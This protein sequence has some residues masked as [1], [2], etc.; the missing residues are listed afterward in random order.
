[1]EIAA[2]AG[3]LAVGYAL[4][5]GGPAS[6]TAPVENEEEGFAGSV[7]YGPDGLPT[8]PYG[9]MPPPL[10]AEDRTAPGA[11]T[12][13]GKPRQPNRLADGE[14]DLYYKLPSGGE[15][16]SNP[17]TQPDLYARDLVFSA[18]APTL[19]PQAPP[20]AVTAQV[21]MNNDSLEAPPVY[22]SG[23]TVISSLTGLPITSEEFSHNNMTPF[24][25]GAPKQNMSDEANR[26]VLDNKVGTGYDQVGKREQAPLFDPHR[27]P[28]GNVFGLESIT[29]FMQ[30]RMIAPTNRKNE[31]PVE[32]TRVGP[33]LN[34]G[35]SSLP[36]GGFQQFDIDEVMKQRLSVDETRVESNPKISYEGQIIVGKSMA[37][38]RGELGEVRKYNPDSFY[39]NQ[40]GERNFVTV[41]EN[42]KAMERPTQVMKFQSRQETTT[43]HFGTAG[44]AESKATYNVPSFRAPFARQHDSFGYRN[45]DG[46]TYGVSNPD[47]E[48]NDFGRAGYDLPTNQRNV[49]S[50][51]GQALN[52]TVAGGPKALTVY[53]PEGWMARTTIRETTAAND[54]VGIAAPASAATKL[55]VYDP[56]DIT[57]V[58]GRNTLAEPD[59]ALN[60]TRAGMPGQRTLA[61]PDGFRLTSKEQISANS[62]YSGVAQIAGQKAEQVYD[63]AYAMR[64]NP[65]KEL[66]A[67]GR[68]P[69][70]GNGSLP[71]FNGEDYMNVT[72]RSLDSDVVNDRD[73]T[74]DRVVGPPLGAEAIGL[75]RPKQTLHLDIAGDRNIHEVLDSLN[76]NPYALPVHKIAA[77]LPTN[78]HAPGPAEMA[79]SGMSA[80]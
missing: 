28:T 66:V 40:D 32:A 62:A 29:D 46:S 14:Y 33:G 16:P 10:Y 17:Y 11:A 2:I 72:Y 47:A 76:D 67:S 1:M 51:R 42:K 24:Y 15:L 34:Q 18:P 12:V 74:V 57:R 68:R 45:A 23:R 37:T 13:P 25:R 70:A 39:I 56:A 60:V 41:G 64:Q 61:F 8:I 3:L 20:T 71:L 77:G 52:L 55:T 36:T 58:T 4:T 75:Q 65:T 54:W 80:W 43:E 22:N 6:A 69:V 38:Q 44:Q 50:E 30:D 49:T 48:N 5:K 21:R 31:V 63:Y 9:G 78:N 26:S 35:Y 79:V 73:S 53:D 19:T 7:V 27:E 59:K